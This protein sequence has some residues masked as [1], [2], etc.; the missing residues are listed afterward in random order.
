MLLLIYCD[1][2]MFSYFKEPDYGSLY[3]GRNPGFYVEA[4]QMPNFKVIFKVLCCKTFVPGWLKFLNNKNQIISLNFFSVL[5]KP[6]M[7]IK[8]REMMNS[9]LQRTLSSLMWTNKKVDG[10]L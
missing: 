2:T 8:L 9:P 7:S 5:L 1:N 4:N 6:C 3:E 10:K